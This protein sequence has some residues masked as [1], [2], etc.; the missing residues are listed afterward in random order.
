MS[1]AGPIT[2]TRDCTAVQ[3]P[4]GYAVTLKAG[5]HV[6]ITQSLG[7]TYTVISEEGIMARIAAEDADAIGEKPKAQAPTGAGAA[8][9]PASKEEL[10]KW[11]M[12]QLRT[13]FD[14]EIPVN[15]VDLGLVYSCEVKPLPE[16]S[17]QYEIQIKMTLTAPGCGMGGVLKADAEQKILK[18]PG[19]KRVNVEV[20][21]DPPWNPSLMSE[22]AKLQLGML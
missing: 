5:T 3:I 13:V 18:L 11:V 22:A 10:E 14:P 21:V 15:V 7:G 17:L 19:V 8:Q 20:V 2:L 1:A 16:D 6:R 9:G 12:G 4:N